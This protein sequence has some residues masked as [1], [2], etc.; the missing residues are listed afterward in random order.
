MSREQT[1][2]ARSRRLALAVV[3]AAAVSFAAQAGAASP[4]I[5]YM[6]QCQGCH[7]P[8]G[9]GKPGAVPS[10]RDSIGLFTT[11][12]GGRAFLIR[13][14]GSASSPLS[15]EALAAVLNWMIRQFGPPAVAGDFRAFDAAEVARH[16]AT[17]LI[18]VDGMRRALVAEI[19]SLGSG[20][21]MD[22]DAAEVDEAVGQSR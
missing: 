5:D 9:T 21:A 15:D 2:Q 7:L 11:V 13:V 20:A 22:A 16:R 19:R 8:D 17:P 3:C 4:H 14:P 18:D 1:H 10:L 6:L 12:A